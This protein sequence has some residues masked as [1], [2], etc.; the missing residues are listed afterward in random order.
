MLEFN[1]S[2][3]ARVKYSPEIFPTEKRCD[4]ILT[5]TYSALSTLSEYKVLILE[6]IN[7]SRTLQIRRWCFVLITNFANFPIYRHTFEL[8]PS[9]HLF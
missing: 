1:G 3:M 7:E 5:S 9:N 8:H 2:A 6:H 4:I